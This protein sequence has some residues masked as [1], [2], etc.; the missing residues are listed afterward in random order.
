MV[1]RKTLTS[2]AREIGLFFYW[3][4]TKVAKASIE[5]L[6]VNGELFIQAYGK[7]ASDL[8]IGKLTT[9]ENSNIRINDTEGWGAAI[10]ITDAE[11]KSGTT[12]PNINRDEGLEPVFKTVDFKNINAADSTIVNQAN[13]KIN[14]G[15]PTG[16]NILSVE[17]TAENQISIGAEC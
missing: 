4:Q 11:F 2:G 8:E 12:F 15:K 9:E 16:S 17:D 14:I 13:G 5:E 10:H 1:C 6:N 3:F 7:E